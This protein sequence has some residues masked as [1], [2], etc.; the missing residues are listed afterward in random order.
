[1]F[2]SCKLYHIYI[3]TA[4]SLKN[5]RSIITALKRKLRNNFNISVAEVDHQD[6]WKN[7][8]IAISV[9]GTGKRYVQKKSSAIQKFINQKF[10]ELEVTKIEDYF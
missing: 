3:P 7:S 10:Y 1:M 9:V 5:K 2:L 8:T 4:Q 6:L